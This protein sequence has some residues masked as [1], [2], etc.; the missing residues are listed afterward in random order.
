MLVLTLS[1]VVWQNTCSALKQRGTLW[2]VQAA[3]VRQ[4]DQNLQI[5]LASRAPF[6]GPQNDPAEFVLFGA[7]Q[8]PSKVLAP[9]R[10]KTLPRL[11]VTI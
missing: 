11:E 1:D 3:T 10:L 8:W 6:S 5:N 4:R 7:K 9:R 2:E